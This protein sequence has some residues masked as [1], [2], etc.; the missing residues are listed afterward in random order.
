LPP[1]VLS[2]SHEGLELLKARQYL[3]PLL[4]VQAHGA[5]FEID[6]E[7]LAHDGG[8]ALI[9]LAGERVLGKLPELTLGSVYLHLRTPPAA[10]PTTLRAVP[11]AFFGVVRVVDIAV[12][13]TLYR[14]PLTSRARLRNACAF[15]Q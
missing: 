9:H 4:S 5:R 14:Y 8:R 7:N 11:P 12:A 15:S 13:R 6:V 1:V 3:Q 2:S 10:T